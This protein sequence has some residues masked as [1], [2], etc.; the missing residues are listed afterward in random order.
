MSIKS[1]LFNTGS[2]L[3]ETLAMAAQPKEPQVA[4]V[5]LHLLVAMVNAEACEHILDAFVAEIGKQGLGVISAITEV[6]P[7]I[8]DSK[9]ELQPL[10]AQTIKET[11]DATEP[12][13]PAK[14]SL[15]LPTSTGR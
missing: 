8:V 1:D 15:I 14:P 9:G 5:S 12:D 13:A 3:T 2:K 6:V 11:V 10:L 7:M 4:T